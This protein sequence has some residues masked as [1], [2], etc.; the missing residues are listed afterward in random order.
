MAKLQ[1]KESFSMAMISLR[2]N[3]LRTF[4]T[5]LGIIIGVLTIIAVVSVIQGL[6]NY[7][8]TKMSFYGANDFAVSKFSMIGTSLKDF[9]EQMKRKDITLTEMRLLRERCASCE[10]VGASTSTSRTAKY[11]NQ[12]LQGTEI[13]GVTYLDHI[14]GSVIE[15]ESGRHIQKDDEDHSR[16]ICVIG[17]DITEKL[18]AGVDPVGRWLKVGTDN[19]LVVG[20]GKKKGKILGFSQDNYVRI[21]ITT[22]AKAYGSRRSISINIHT[23]SQ[24]QMVQA[25]EEVRTILRSWRKRTYKDPDDF[26]FQTS[27]TFIQFYKTATSGIY[28]AM[29]AISSIALVVGGIVIMNIM[30]VSVTERTKEIGI[31][32]AVG[33]RRKDI[34]FQFLIESSFM[35]A[36]G[37]IIG[38]VLGVAVARVITAATS[39]PSRVE[40]GSVVLAIV[41]ST[42]IGL[43]FGLY[44]ANRAAKLDPIEA[45]RTEQ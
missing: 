36:W 34:L 43:F 1:I 35:S 31:R 7:V 11:R 33:A 13:R 9:K 19:F 39:M 2:A 25:Q 5:L 21:P 40:P 28:F 8:Y 20:A 16:Y 44:P 14:I 15:L 10:L 41:M 30:L 17:S 26:S 3:K 4:L 38:V 24:E 6:N 27:E 18:F 32:M 23:A 22:F 29:I 37:G 45:L 12:S 42:S